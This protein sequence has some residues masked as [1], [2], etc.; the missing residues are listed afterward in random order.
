M[1][2]ALFV[3]GAV[4]LIWFARREP[5]VTTAV[6]TTV[7]VP[8]PQAAQPHV[9]PTPTPTQQIDSDP[10]VAQATRRPV[11]N[12][13]RLPPP[14]PS[15]Q[16]QH[17]PAS[18]TIPTVTELADLYARVGR[19]LTNATKRDSASTFD[20]WPRYRWIRFMDAAKT[21]A[22][23]EAAAVILQRLQTDLRALKKP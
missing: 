22:K 17:S 11:T 6:A 15:A 18:T 9:V 20:L 10:I 12:K 3:C 16:I 4:A 2:L 1:A 13:P 7:K 14:P 21:P 8:A 19:E 5:T 23:R